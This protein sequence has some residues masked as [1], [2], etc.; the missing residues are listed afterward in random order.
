MLLTAIGNRTN[1]VLQ[2]VTVSLI[3]IFVIVITWG[4][5]KWIAKIQ[6]GQMTG[7]VNI[8]VIETQRI[9]TDQ[10]LQIVRAGNKYV[11]IAVGKTETHMITELSE[12]ELIFEN[13]ETKNVDF[14]SVLEKF[15]ATNKKE[16]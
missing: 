13:D 16:D 6:K 8:E 9:N 5:T 10:Y 14:A 2:F 11:L 15:K 1:S 4:T 12:D 3:F 7:G